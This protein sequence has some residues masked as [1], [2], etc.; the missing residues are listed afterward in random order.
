MID[1]KK[2]YISVG[3][4]LLTCVGMYFLGFDKNEIILIGMAGMGGGLT[5]LR[6]AVAKA[7]QDATKPKEAT[8]EK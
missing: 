2:T 3:L 6:H 7:S 1:G 4:T 5:S 8:D